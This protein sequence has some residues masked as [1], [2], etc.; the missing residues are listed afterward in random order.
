[1]TSEYTHG[2][3]LLLTGG[4]SGLGQAIAEQ[5]QAAGYE[6]LVLDR[7]PSTDSPHIVVDLQDTD[8]A[9]AATLEAL[10]R[11]GG[12]D[13]LVLCA[14]INRPER[15]EHQDV[16][17]WKSVLEV[18]VF[19]NAAVT[20]ASIGALKQSHGRIVGIGSTASRRLTSG[21]SAYGASKHA[22]TAFL[23]GIAI[24]EMG[25][26]GVSIV[27][28]GMMETGFFSGR[29]PE[30]VPPANNRLDPSDVARA[31]L[32]CLSQPAHVA[33]RDMYITDVTVRDW[34]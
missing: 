30:F 12:L 11:L 22:F 33:V 34:P 10:E 2:K 15:F 7:N 19:G 16:A 24:E 9:E 28:P 21:M 29:R 26:L 5:A 31:V 8:A 18:N 4:T 20:R 6:L 1:M 13:A 27:H 32:F 25:N 3:K 17:A 14:G 23:H